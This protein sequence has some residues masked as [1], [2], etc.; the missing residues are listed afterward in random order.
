[1]K[2]HF[3]CLAKK[4]IVFLVIFFSSHQLFAQVQG[5][6][7]VKQMPDVLPTSWCRA[8]GE[9]CLI[10]VGENDSVIY[11]YDLNSSEWHEH[12]Q[13]TELPWIYPARAAKDVAIV[14][15]D[16]IVVAY[17]AVSYSFIS[18][19][20]QGTLLNSTSSS[21]V[22]LNG[23]TENAAYFV[24]DQYFY[25]FDAET[26]Q[27][28]SHPISGLGTLDSKYAYEKPGYVLITLK[29]DADNVKL[30]AYSISN[31]S[32]KEWNYSFSPS[33]EYLDYGFVAWRIESSHP[34]NEFFGCYS[35]IHDTWIS[36]DGIY[37]AYVAI[38]SDAQN[39][40]P[41][42]VFMF[43]VSTVL[44]HPY[45]NHTFYIYNTLFP[46]A[47]VVS[48]STNDD[49][50]IHT[51]SAGAQTAVISFMNRNDN[52]LEILAYQSDTHSI[53]PCIISPLHVEQDVNWHSCGGVIYVG[54]D[55]DQ[56]IGGYPNGQHMDFAPMPVDYE[57][58][59]KW[60]RD[61]EAR[62]NWGIMLFE[63]KD[64]DTAYVYSYNINN[65]DTLTHFSTE[66]GNY[67]FTKISSDKD[68]A[69]LLGITTSGYNLFLYSP[70]F[71]VWTQKTAGPNSP[72]I[73]LSG[74]FIYY[75]EPNSNLLSVFN[76]ATNQELDLPFGRTGIIAV[77][78]Y[79][80]SGENFLIAYTA[81]N[82]YVSYS[83][84]TGTSSEY[85]S[86][87]YS[88]IRGEHSIWTSQKGNYDILTYNS[89]SDSFIP[90]TLS[91][92]QGLCKNINVG[93]KTALILTINGYLLAFDPYKNSGTA[94]E[95]MTLD[96]DTP[97][98]FNLAQNYPNP[99]NPT[100]T[101]N[102][103]IPKHTLVELTITDI[104][105]KKVQ[106]LVEKNMMPGI[107]KYE[108]DGSRLASGVYLY[109]LKTKEFTQVKKMLLVK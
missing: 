99:F 1:M 31:E 23:C 44:E 19:D 103:S 74:D 78:D 101:I 39:L 109:M 14:Y 108:F 82:K 60:E 11:A 76:G 58:S 20:Y 15:T 6:W 71:D 67:S 98:L 30:M 79:T 80:Y 12:L 24:T 2:K 68:V 43:R 93:G 66:W 83:A 92:T 64:A 53:N 42:T 9:N 55:F 22:K 4:F 88:Y 38:S 5:A 61:I 95:N 8:V 21:V 47:C 107:Y 75:H 102:F 105:G 33:I 7:V 97:E 96:A 100:T 16:S 45:Y 90:L 85:E 72:A 63:D 81:D 36:Q 104:L 34:E 94:I 59:Y 50:S 13:P 3:F 48:R 84:L 54:N 62:D 73:N 106:T 37:F 51:Y 86:D 32:F 28:H 40:S 29:D 35:A 57:M 26:G 70:V 65:A 87:R 52:N 10:Y 17:S 27:W 91:D 18:L 77:R 25:A 41:R 49:Y 56:V 69:G 89:I 46:D